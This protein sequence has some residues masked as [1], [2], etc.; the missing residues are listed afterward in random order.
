MQA[1]S[2][3]AAGAA[4]PLSLEVAQVALTRQELE[5]LQP[6]DIADIWKVGSPSA[7]ALECKKSSENIAILLGRSGVSLESLKDAADM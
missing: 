4:Q 2:G 1:S 3:P 5:Q 7:A 6:S